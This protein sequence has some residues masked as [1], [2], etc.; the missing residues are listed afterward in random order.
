MFMPVKKNGRPSTTSWCPLRWTKPGGTV[1]VTSGV[2]RSARSRPHADGASEAIRA[3]TTHRR[4]P[5]ARG[6]QERPL[7]DMAYL[8]RGSRTEPIT[9]HRWSN[10]GVRPNPAGGHGEGEQRKEQIGAAAHGDV[11]VEGHEDEDDEQA[12]E[13]GDPGNAEGAGTFPS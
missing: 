13:A 2:V 8:H 1:G 10:P 9:R 5:A 12:R 3:I 4:R 11:R 6:W 7:S